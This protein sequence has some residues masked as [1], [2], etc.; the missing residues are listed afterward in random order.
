MAAGAASLLVAVDTHSDASGLAATVPRLSAYP[1]PDLEALLAM[2]PDLVLVWAAGLSSATLARLESLGLQVYVSEPRRLDDIPLTLERF[3]RLLGDVRAPEASRAASAFRQTVA[4]LRADHAQGPSLPVFVQIWSQ[5][6]MSIGPG[7]VLDD[8]LKICG[9][10]NVLT[11]ART[12]SVRVDAET[13]LA[14][15]PALII[16]TRTDTSDEYW[17]RV[18]LL[19][20]RGSAQFVAMDGTLLERASPAML[21]PLQALCA[22]VQERR[23]SFSTERR[24]IP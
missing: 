18:G 7:S 9:A 4:K 2:R 10:H 22:H 8:S 17:R 19:R 21:A 3:A 13:V 14:R 23:Q 24:A 6:L 16:A 1:Q 12:A 5:P 20:P 15:A 11:D